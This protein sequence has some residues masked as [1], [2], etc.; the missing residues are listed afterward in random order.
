LP[1]RSWWSGC[2]WSRMASRWCWEGAW[3]TASAAAGCCSAGCS[4]SPS[5]RRCVRSHE[6]DGAGARPR[7]AGF[8]CG[9]DASPGAA[10]HPGR[11]AGAAAPRRSAPTAQA[12]PGRWSARSSAAAAWRCCPERCCLAA[13]ADRAGAHARVLRVQHRPVRRLDL[14]SAGRP[15]RQPAWSRESPSRRPSTLIDSSSPTGKEGPVGSEAGRGRR[16]RDATKEALCGASCA[17]GISP[18]TCASLGGRPRPHRSLAQPAGTRNLHC[19]P[20]IT[21]VAVVRHGSSAL[22]V[23]GWSRRRDRPP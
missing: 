1:P 4:R 9:R 20:D 22:D 14:L 5:A 15:S 3:V 11:H 17:A 13:G 16:Q 23:R 18:K 6:R 8:L 7:A 19:S 10:D 12:A 2:T 21:N